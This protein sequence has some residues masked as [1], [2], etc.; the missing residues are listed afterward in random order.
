LARPKNALLGVGMGQYSSRAALITSNEYLGRDL[1]DMVSAKSGYFSDSMMPA[2]RV[3][4]EI[5]EGSAISKPYFSVL[6]ILVELGPPLTLACLV[7]MFFHFRRNFAW[8]QSKNP[9]LA[10]IGLVSCVGLLFFLLCCG[11]ENYAEFPQA[12]FLPFLLYL[13][14]Q[15][16]ASQLDVN[17]HDTT[18]TTKMRPR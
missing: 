10:R 11:I 1:P 13:A 8:M 9:H 18:S 17:H 7:G 3:F 4:G 16:R 12:I 14:A 2:L 5:G 15:S 6:T